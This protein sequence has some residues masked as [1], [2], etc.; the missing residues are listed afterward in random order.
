[1]GTGVCDELN[2]HRR[3]STQVSVLQNQCVFAFQKRWKEKG[4][5]PAYA[6]QTFCSSNAEIRAKKGEAEEWDGLKIS[7]NKNKQHCLYP[8]SD[9]HFFFFLE[10]PTETSLLPLFFYHVTGSQCTKLA[11]CSGPV[12]CSTT[13]CSSTLVKSFLNNI[14]VLGSRLS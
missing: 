7:D 10:I 5:F 12:L 9:T 11:A 14:S 2:G 1:M 13:Y 3:L 6:F 8:T 4:T